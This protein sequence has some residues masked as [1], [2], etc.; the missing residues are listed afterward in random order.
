MQV[1]GA[2]RTE[3]A[4]DRPSFTIDVTHEA[5]LM[6]ALSVVGLVDTDSI[7]PDVAYFSDVPHSPQHCMSII[8]DAEACFA[9]HCNLVL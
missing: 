1:N 7:D 9:V 5:D 4:E 3:P 6:A 2:T 8:C